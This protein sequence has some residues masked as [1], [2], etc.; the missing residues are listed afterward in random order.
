MNLETRTA[1]SILS[2]VLLI[3]GMFPYII[4]TIKRKIQPAKT[5]WI[6]W[7]FVDYLVLFGMIS[8]GAFNWQIAAACV[9]A[10]IIMALSI[11]LGESG[12]TNLD[13]FC[14]AGAGLG[15][16]LWYF[17]GNGLFGVVIGTS[18]GT[19][20]S[21]PT[22]ASTMEDPKKESKFTWSVFAVSS[23]LSVIAIPRFSVADAM[24]PVFYFLVGLVMLYLLFFHQRIRRRDGG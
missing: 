19:L 17:S 12:W 16:L 6:I 10:T 14:L 3:V 1:L 18:I 11:K 21:F 7:A 9:S 5:T 2:G 13:K 22:F 23:A 15:A 4:L 24:Q 20:G 8:E